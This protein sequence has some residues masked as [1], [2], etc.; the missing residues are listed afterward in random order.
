MFKKLIT[1]GL[2][3]L[4]FVS[5]TTSAQLVRTDW[6]NEG[7]NKVLYDTNSGL[8]WLDNGVLGGSIQSIVEEMVI[9]GRLEGWT[10]ASHEQVTS[11]FSANGNTTVYN[12]FT[13]TSNGTSKYVAQRWYDLETDDIGFTGLRD[14]VAYYDTSNGYET[15]NTY[16]WWLVRKGPGGYDEET[17]GSLADLSGGSKHFTVPD[18]YFNP[19]DVSVGSVA[20]VLGLL[21]F[22]VGGGSSSNRF[23]KQT[24]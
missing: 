9:G 8:E 11:L 13:K 18:G 19:N 22:L 12:T 24:A 17:S 10:F 2:V 23:R 5:L 6:Y 7:D 21:F 3:A 14:R 15:S 16:G 1:L 20:L 4:S